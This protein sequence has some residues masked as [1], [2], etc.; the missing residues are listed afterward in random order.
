M[1]MI[2][3]DSVLQYWNN[4]TN[5]QVVYLNQSTCHIAH[6]TVKRQTDGQKN[7]G[8]NRLMQCIMF[9]YLR[10]KDIIQLVPDT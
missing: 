10:V 9:A 8:D 5:T 2:G 4:I 7:Q 3:V 1:M 6:R